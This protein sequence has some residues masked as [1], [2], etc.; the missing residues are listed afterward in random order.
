LKEEL[1]EIKA[2]SNKGAHKLIKYV[3]DHYKIN[4]NTK[5]EITEDD[6]KHDKINKTMLKVISHFHPDKVSTND[7]KRKILHEEITKYL[8]VHY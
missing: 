3:C 5:M 7:M 1:S 8:N 2:A 4:N 6:L